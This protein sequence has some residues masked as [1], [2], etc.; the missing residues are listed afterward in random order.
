VLDNFQAGHPPETIPSTLNN[1]V[2][3][4]ILRMLVGS[5]QYCRNQ[6]RIHNRFT[7]ERRNA[8]GETAS[9]AA[10]VPLLSDEWDDESNADFYAVPNRLHWLK[11]PNPEEPQG[12]TTF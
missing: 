6:A 4:Q 12:W 1:G 3:G 8:N 5:T 9:E 2:Q 10:A 7:S 11:L